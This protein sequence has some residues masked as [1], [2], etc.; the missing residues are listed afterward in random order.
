MEPVG[1][2]PAPHDDD[3][4]PGPL[5]GVVRPVA[6]HVWQLGPLP[7]SPFKD[8]KSA[9]A[10]GG[11]GELRPEPPCLAVEDEAGVINGLSVPAAGDPPLSRGY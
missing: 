5:A 9:R 6:G 11:G 8:G 2:A 10:D 3:I 7:R 4:V 1:G